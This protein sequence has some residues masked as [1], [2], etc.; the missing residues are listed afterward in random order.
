MSLVGSANRWRSSRSVRVGLAIGLGLTARKVADRVTSRPAE[1]LVDWPR[2]QRIAHRRL[3]RAP[4]RLTPVQLRAAAPAYAR[5]ME[6]VVPLLEARLGS[7]AA[8]RRRAPR[9]GQ[10]GRVGECQHRHVPEPS[11]AI[12]SRASCPVPGPAA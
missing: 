4:G 7:R 3:L 2:A 12:S 5:H 9:R 1:G 11:S 8:W 6:R 10:P